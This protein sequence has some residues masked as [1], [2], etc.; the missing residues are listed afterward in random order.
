MAKPRIDDDRL[1]AAALEEFAAKT[2]EEA[3]VNRIIEKAGISKGSFY[4]R[5]GNKFE[6]YLFLLR[7]GYR[8][9]WE[10]IRREMEKNGGEGSEGD[11]FSLFLRQAG[12]GIR[13]AAAHGDYHRL[14]G[15]FAREKGSDHYE[16]ALEKLGSAGEEG[17]EG[18]VSEAIEKGEL[19][20]GFTPDFHLKVFRFLFLN[21]DAFFPDTR[22]T[23]PET[24]MDSMKDFVRFMKHGLAAG[25]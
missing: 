4:Y 17:L 14:A 1:T 21:Y 18:L 9:K 11:I 6:L 25:H 13:F 12:A 20:S 24:L 7:E 22:E 5:F 10:F 8:K 16:K 2:Y 19:N 3:S 15:M 23:D